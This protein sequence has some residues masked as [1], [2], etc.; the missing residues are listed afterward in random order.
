MV[1]FLVPVHGHA[2]AAGAAGDAAAS[3]ELALGG[4]GDGA[5]TAGAH[6]GG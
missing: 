4:R 3:R 5:G 1:V 2:A 6:L